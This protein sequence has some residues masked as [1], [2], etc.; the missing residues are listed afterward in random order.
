MRL[1]DHP[2]DTTYIAWRLY[3][4]QAPVISHAAIALLSVAGSE[5]AVE[6]SFSAQGLVHSSRRS[7]LADEA[8]EAEMFIKF[9]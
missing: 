6:R 1:I 9:N 3:L 5:A 2:L 8:V 4:Q 7:Q